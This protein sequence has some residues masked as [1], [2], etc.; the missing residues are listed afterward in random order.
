MKAAIASAPLIQ[1]THPP[2]APVFFAL[3]YV[4]AVAVPGFKYAAGIDPAGISR[5][6][7]E[8]KKYKEDPLVK[9]TATLGTRK[10]LCINK[11]FH[12]T[13]QNFLIR[14]ACF[15]ISISFKKSQRYAGERRVTSEDVCQDHHSDF[16]SPRHS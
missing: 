12:P 7:E 3:K 6:S 13:K 1:L 8:V 9:D 14:M 10:C 11:H 16:G 5:D 4:A 15:K 2:A